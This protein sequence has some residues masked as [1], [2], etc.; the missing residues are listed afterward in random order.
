MR[1]RAVRLERKTR[2]TE[3]QQGQG[4]TQEQETYAYREPGSVSEL[5]VSQLGG[6]D[7]T[8]DLTE[9]FL[10]K[11]TIASLSKSKGKTTQAR[12]DDITDSWISVSTDVTDT[13]PGA[14]SRAPSR[15]GSVLHTQAH[16]QTHTRA[17]ALGSSTL[18]SNT[19]TPI[20]SSA[21]NTTTTSTLSTIATPARPISRRDERQHERERDRD[22]ESTSPHTGASD[23]SLHSV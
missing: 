4:Q 20:G 9:P 3:A 21:I 19:P 2:A 11:G 8:H 14:A 5:S 17:P 16:T 12:S 15:S 23:V 22:R 10:G 7:G 1:Q 18:Y 6:R 13:Q